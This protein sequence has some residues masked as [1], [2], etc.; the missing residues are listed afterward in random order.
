[1]QE[2]KI[3][4]EQIEAELCEISRI[5]QNLHSKKSESEEILRNMENELK[6][7][8]LLA[9]NLQKE[10]QSVC[11]SDQKRLPVIVARKVDQ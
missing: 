1:M 10:L 7:R 9:E 5:L 8:F 3:N 11:L 6:S 4:S 2:E